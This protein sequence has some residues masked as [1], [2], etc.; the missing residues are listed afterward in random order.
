[1]PRSNANVASTPLELKESAEALSI[2]SSEKPTIIDS[3]ASRTIFG[4]K[5]LFSRYH[6]VKLGQ[7]YVANQMPVKVVGEGTLRF[8]TVV[9]GEIQFLEIN[10]ALYVPEIPQTLISI[11]G[12]RESGYLVDFNN[13]ENAFVISKN[14]NK[15]I[16]VAHEQHGLYPLRKEVWTKVTASSV[17]TTNH[18]T[19][20]WH[21]RLGHLNKNDMKKLARNHMV[22]GLLLNLP[23]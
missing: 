9:D 18:D 7:V 17:H 1:M 8:S 20:L 23:L 15:V 16:A 10:D 5:S 19:L 11:S 12:I 22:D 21:K 14:S 13:V 6:A 4:N 3:G 2:N